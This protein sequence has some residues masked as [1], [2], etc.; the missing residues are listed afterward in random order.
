M[1]VLILLLA[2]FG[3]VRCVLA[4]TLELQLSKIIASLTLLL[5]LS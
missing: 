1:V 2:Y 4:L 3:A 5:I